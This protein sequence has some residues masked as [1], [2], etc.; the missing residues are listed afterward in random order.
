MLPT[1]MARLGDNR[2]AQAKRYKNPERSND[3]DDAIAWIGET[4]APPSSDTLPSSDGMLP[5]QPMIVDV[6]LPDSWSG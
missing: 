4:T 1:P 2:G 6:L 3:L 5:F